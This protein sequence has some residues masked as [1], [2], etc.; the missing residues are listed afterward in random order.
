[1]NVHLNVRPDFKPGDPAPTGY[2]DWHEWA[3]VQYRSGLRQ[4]RCGGCGK[5]LFPQEFKDHKCGPT[6]RN[7]EETP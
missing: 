3:S 7:G 5:C 4:R 1:M 2:L 6:S